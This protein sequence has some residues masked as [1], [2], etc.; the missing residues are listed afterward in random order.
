MSL[1]SIWS[2]PPDKPALLESGTILTVVA[3]LFS[4]VDI[5]KPTSPCNAD[6]SFDGDVLCAFT[7]VNRSSD[8][9]IACSAATRLG[10][11]IVANGSRAGCEYG[12]RRQ[13]RDSQEVMSRLEMS[14]AA[15]S[16]RRAA[17]TDG[18]GHGYSNQVLHSLLRRSQSVMT[19]TKRESAASHLRQGP[20]VDLAQLREPANGSRGSR[21][22]LLAFSGFALALYS[23]PVCLPFY[24]TRTTLVPVR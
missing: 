6:V 8:R 2:I 19:L 18:S 23:L 7:P 17:G 3:M 11:A 4:V 14:R 21:K 22:F 5:R 20:A 10:M 1:T 24:R 13:R 12:D 9:H 15:W 16:G